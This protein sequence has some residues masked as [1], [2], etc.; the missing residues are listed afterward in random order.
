M[1]DQSP[2]DLGGVKE[3]RDRAGA[4]MSA[5]AVAGGLAA[6]LAFNSDRVRGIDEFG[7][8]GS[9]VAVLGFVGVTVSTVMI[10][11]P[12]EGRFLHDA[13]VIIG[14]YVEGDPPAQLSEIHRD[15]ALWLGQQMKANRK[16]LDSHLRIFTFGL[17][18]LLAEV[19]G[20]IVA[21][22]DVAGG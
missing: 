3:T 19:G 14:S 10:W 15:L 1:V 2:P 5:A 11:R 7:L 18:A 6:G 17:V 8:V 16:M 13:G 4:L 20:V 12:T 9:L 21:L 22:G